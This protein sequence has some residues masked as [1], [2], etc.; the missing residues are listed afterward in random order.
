M[1]VIRTYACP[2]CNFMMDVTCEWDAGPPSCPECDRRDMQQEFKPFAIGGS[3]TSRAHAIAEDI[4]AN[5]YHVADMNI[6]RREGAKPT[7]RYKDQPAGRDPATWGIGSSDLQAAVAVGRQNR[8]TY[9]SGLDVLQSNIR[10]GLEPDLIANS[11]K[12]MIKLY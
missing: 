6:D 5:D 2:A 11:K 12:Q 3:A 1:P 8:L 4:A 7:V 9:G 10:S